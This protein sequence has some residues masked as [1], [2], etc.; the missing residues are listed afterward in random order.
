MKRPSDDEIAQALCCGE[1]CTVGPNT[2]RC[3]RWDFHGEVQRV[4]AL[5]TKVRDGTKEKEADEV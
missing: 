2:G 3:H 4:Q 5:L 1:K